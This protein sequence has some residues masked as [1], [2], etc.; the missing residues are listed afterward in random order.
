MS[1]C[2]PIWPKLAAQTTYG[3]VLNWYPVK[4]LK[5]IIAWSRLDHSWGSQ[6]SFTKC[7]NSASK[8]LTYFLKR[9]KKKDCRGTLFTALTGERKTDCQRVLSTLNFYSAL[10]YY[11]FFFGGWGSTFYW[12]LSEHHLHFS[13]RVQLIHARCSFKAKLLRSFAFIKQIDK[14]GWITP[15]PLTSAMTLLIRACLRI[16]CHLKP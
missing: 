10:L 12:P 16:L 9:K 6:R 14:D 5:T 11:L 1:H 15:T 2:L 4:N 13:T 7:I 3:L 8:L